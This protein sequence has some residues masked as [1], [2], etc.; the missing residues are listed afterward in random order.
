M[1]QSGPNRC[2][3]RRAIGGGYWALS[4][5]VVSEVTS[6]SDPWSATVAKGERF[7]ERGC[8]YAVAIN[9]ETRAVMPLGE[10]PNELVL[11]VDA[12]IDTSV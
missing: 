6:K 3:R 12:I 11:D 9:P 7:M 10:P 1:G 4:P 2:A 8:S 5:D